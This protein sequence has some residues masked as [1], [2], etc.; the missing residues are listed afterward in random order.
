MW[1]NDCK[2]KSMQNNA[3]QQLR[4]L[5]GIEANTYKLNKMETDFASLKRGMDDITTRGIK[6]RS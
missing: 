3:T 5:A 6:I 1:G 2:K 4:H